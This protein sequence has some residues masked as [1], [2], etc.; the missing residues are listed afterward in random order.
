[1]SPCPRHTGIGAE[2]R[3]RQLAR[4]AQIRRVGRRWA[5]PSQSR[6]AERYLVDVE[7]A[8]CTCPDY[9]E[10]RG[11]CK[12]QHAVLFW[13]AWGRDVGADGTVTETVVVRRRT[14]RQKDWRAYDASQVH[15]R[16]YVERLLRALCAGVPQP[17]RTPGPGRKPLAIGDEVFSAVM[18][19]YTRLPG[20]RAQSDLREAASRDHLGKVAH[21]TAIQKFL[22]DPATTA[23]LTSLVEQSA[24][25]LRVIEAGQ[26][27][28]DS[29]GFSTAV[30]DRWFS[31]KHGRLCSHNSWVKL[32]V[33][34]GT[35]THAVTSAAVTSEGDCP[36]LPALLARTRADHDVRE[37]SADKAYSSVDNHEVLDRLQIAA[38][39]PFKENAVVNPRSPIWSRHLCEFLLNQERF[40][41]H[42]H[43]RS[44][45]ETTFAMIKAKFGAAVMSRLPVAQ[46]NEVLSKCVAHNLCCL[47]RRSSRRGSLRRS[48]RTRRRRRHRR[49]APR[50]RR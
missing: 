16:A 1:M 19:I 8:A 4:A 17:A 43:R 7:G 44:N 10:R 34:V 25:P 47:V 15:E 22:A 23:I 13:I 31:Q 46:V 49:P 42:Y 41:T 2:E 28:V 39:I 9:E 38:Y 36:Q 37:L 33:M 45:V 20:R 29:S 27:A 18:K 48:G 3:G 11:T 12:H 50:S 21:F 26:Y 40:L 35:V 32:H 30:Y 14:Y 24:A 6:A 5:V